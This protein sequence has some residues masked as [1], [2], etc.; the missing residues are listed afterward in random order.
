MSAAENRHLL[1]EGLHMDEPIKNS[2]RGFAAM[3]KTMRVEIASKGGRCAHEKGTAHE[4]DSAQAA[5]AA[6]RA[7][8]LGCAHKFTTDEARTAGRKGGI[9]RAARLRAQNRLACALVLQAAPQ[10]AG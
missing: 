5:T 9:A 4:F 1:L 3:D 2:R 7:H 10:M 6:R 8:E